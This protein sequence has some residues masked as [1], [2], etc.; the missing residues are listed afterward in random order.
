MGGPLRLRLAAQARRGVVHRA[1]RREAE[2]RL[3]VYALRSQGARSGDAV[4]YD[5]FLKR[6]ARFDAPSGFDPGEDM[7]ERMFPF[8]RAITRWACRRGRAAVW[9]DCGL[10]KTIIALEW[11]RLVTAREG[12]RGLVLTP[13]AVSEQFAEEGLKFGIPVN[14]CRDGADVRDGINVTNYERLHR[15]DPASFVAVVADESSILKDYTSSTRNSLIDAFSRTPYR[16]AC[17]ATPAPNDHI[18]LG[19]HAEF[20]GALTRTEMLSTF[21]VHDGGETQS[22]RLK[23]HAAGDFWSWVCSWAVVIRKPS[24]LGFE[25]SGYELPDLQIEDVIVPGDDRVA[26]EMGVLFTVKAETLIEQRAAR[27]GSLTSRVAIASEIV[28]REPDQPWLLWCDLN[29]ESSGLVDAIPGAVEVRG[30]DDAEVKI[31]RLHGFR[32]GKYR[33]LVT[34]PS[35]AGHGMNWQHC[36][37]VIFVGLSHSWEQWYQAIRRTHRFGQKRPVKCYMVSSEAEGAVADNLRRKQKDAVVLFDSMIDAMGDIQ[38]EA[39]C[40][41]FRETS[42]Y[43]ASYRMEIPEWLV[44]EKQA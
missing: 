22:W 44:S 21:F 42:P 40:G 32:T 19:N 33:V 38:R 35:I 31:E 3:A 39:I 17:T 29:D 27:R 8:Q 12:G 26:A 11:L 9:A 15:F 6:K 24:D 36:A 43:Q 1:A 23:R 10:G 18:E 20:L 4:N 16:M 30:S 13:L 28:G 25:D 5:E 41:L 14:L 37:R 2:A 7:N 34:K